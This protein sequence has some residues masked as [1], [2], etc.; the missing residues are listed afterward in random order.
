[1]Q[2]IETHRPGFVISTDPARLQVE[3]VHAFLSERSYWAQG[4]PLETVRRSLENSLCF[5]LYALQP[6]TGGEDQPFDS[7]RQESTWSADCD[8][9]QIG[10][11]RVVTDYA[12]FGWLCDVYVHEDYRGHDLGKWLIASLVEHPDLKTIRRLLLATRDAQELYRRYGGFETL[13]N[14]ERWMARINPVQG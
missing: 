9:T 11:A 2:P 7:A 4:R 10:L 3:A 6:P 14:P 8:Y 1:M 12:T 13:E 5:G